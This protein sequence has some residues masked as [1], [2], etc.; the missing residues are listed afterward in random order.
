MLHQ[1]LQALA[2]KC[3]SC[4]D[5]PHGSTATQSVFAKG[6]PLSPLVFVG[7]APGETDDKEGE[8]FVGESGKL[9]DRMIARMAQ[10]FG[11][12]FPT[13]YICN[14]VKHWPA[15]SKLLKTGED[16]RA[17]TPKLFEQLNL[18]PNVRAIVALGRIAT[19]ILLGYT[20]KDYSIG[21]LRGRSYHNTRT[22]DK[23]VWMDDTANEDLPKSS[24]EW[25]DPDKR[26][27]VVPTWHPSYLLHQPNWMQP[28]HQCWADLQL[29]LQR[30]L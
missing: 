23:L 24:S 29:A 4:R 2:D 19:Q 18:L 20:P 5:C 3:S 1:N 7:E 13:P 15:N 25:R 9:L 27:V 12:K 14:V 8:L 16:V 17:C 6:D 11:S 10:E 21:S 28:R 30:L 22:G 26:I